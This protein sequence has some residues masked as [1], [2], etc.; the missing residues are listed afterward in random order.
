MQFQ[1]VILLLMLLL[2]SRFTEESEYKCSDFHGSYGHLDECPPAKFMLKDH[3]VECYDRYSKSAGRHSF[4]PTY[5]NVFCNNLSF[6]LEINFLDYDSNQYWCWSRLDVSE[7]KI[8]KQILSTAIVD[9]HELTELSK[10]PFSVRYKFNGTHYKCDCSE[11]WANTWFLNTD[12]N[13]SPC[14]TNTSLAV[15]VKFQATDQIL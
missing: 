1:G 2:K 12:Y 15:N 7:D 13:T 4:S 5:L 10:K 8:K 3:L 9:D 14:V 11:E 6:S